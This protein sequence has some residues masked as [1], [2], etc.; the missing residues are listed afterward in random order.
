MPP[1]AGIHC[2]HPL[3]LPLEMLTAGSELEMVGG[4]PNVG[5]GERLALRG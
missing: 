4:K 1:A 3:P 2:H 5:A